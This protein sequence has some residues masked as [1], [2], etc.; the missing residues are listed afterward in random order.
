MTL[1]SSLLAPDGLIR[2]LYRQVV[3]EPYRRYIRTLRKRSPK[4]PPRAIPPPE[5]R[6]LAEA[7]DLL[8]EWRLTDALSRIEEALALQPTLHRALQSA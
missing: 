2:S 1:S 8:A 3:P 4:R 6:L 5:A 7:K